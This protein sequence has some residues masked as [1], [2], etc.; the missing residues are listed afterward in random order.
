MLNHSR[1]S[2][3]TSELFNTRSLFTVDTNILQDNKA[4]WH[5]I[6]RIRN[7]NYS[8]KEPKAEV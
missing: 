5:N 7:H 6:V 2:A 3:E 8:N 1:L 4:T